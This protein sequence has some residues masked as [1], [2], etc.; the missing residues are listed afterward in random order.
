MGLFPKDIG[1]DL[2]TATVLIY[3]KGKGIVLQEPSVVAIKSDTQKVLE[4]GEAARRMIGK[5]PGNIVAIR[6]L[7]DGVIADFDITES[8]LRYFIGKAQAGG[9]LIKPR[10]MICVPSGVTSV[11]KRAVEDA[12]KRAGAREVAIIEE[13]VAAAIGAGLDIS[14]PYGHMIVDIGGGT[15]DVAVISMRGVVVSKSIRIAGDKMD[16]AIVRYIR[17]KYNVIIGERAAEQVKVE[18]GTALEGSDKKTS[19]RGRN[20]LTGLPTVIDITAEE[21]R[22]A[23][24][25]PVEEIINAVKSVLE[26]TPPELAGD[27]SER[28]IVMTGGGALLDGLDRILCQKTNTPVFIAE[29]PISCVAIG[30]GEAL[31]YFNELGTHSRRK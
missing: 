17:S 29:N 4:V 7:R 27:I 5:T 19:V 26:K 25:E 21:I 30:T 11:E 8:M 9:F 2:G 16:E 10:I 14:Q 18:I 22:E 12:A 3:V 15:T 1:I 24:S 20:L 13:P 23:L 31:E 6:P 28:G